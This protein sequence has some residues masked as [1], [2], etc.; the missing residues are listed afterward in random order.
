VQD[1][2]QTAEQVRA[3][4]RR[5]L[6]GVWDERWQKTPTTRR[7]PKGKAQY[8]KGSHSSVYRILHGLHGVCSDTD[9]SKA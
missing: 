8:L 6:A 5:R 4:L 1:G 2:V 7:T 9:K 3:Y